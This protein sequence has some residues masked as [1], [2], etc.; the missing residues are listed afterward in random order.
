MAGA[1]WVVAP[2]AGVNGQLIDNLLPSFW[3][4][5]LSRIFGDTP[6]VGTAKSGEDLSSQG[7][8]AVPRRGKRTPPA[9]RKERAKAMHGAGHSFGEIAKTLGISKSQAYR[10]V[11]S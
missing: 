2:A 7:E 3:S 4:D 1:V 11:N 5:A 9:L 8:T 10:Y 6:V